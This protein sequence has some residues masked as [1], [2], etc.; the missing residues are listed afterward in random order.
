M[1][2]YIYIYTWICI[3]IYTYICINIHIHEYVYIYMYIHICIYIYINMY[4]HTY[5]YP[6]MY[7]HT[8][9][10]HY[11]R[12]RRQQT[13]Q[14]G[15]PLAVCATAA[16]ISPLPAWVH[17]CTF[18]STHTHARTHTNSDTHNTFTHT[19]THTH[20]YIR[21]HTH[22]HT[23]THTSRYA[24]TSNLR[25]SERSSFITDARLDSAVNIS[26]SICASSR[27]SFS[28]AYR[29]RKR[30]AREP[31]TKGEFVREKHMQCVFVYLNFEL[32]AHFTRL[33]R[34]RYQES[35]TPRVRMCET[36]TEYLIVYSCF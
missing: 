30:I 7:T 3:N 15:P 6:H 16:P 36:H 14:C 34:E 23:H 25:W 28:R 22:T 35:H 31:H 12:V 33:R 17:G 32:P 26:L 4:I 24:H 21:T 11:R 1:Y 13:T 18:L 9:T 10:H 5:M 27:C 8:L 20:T 2:M 29:Q 19:H